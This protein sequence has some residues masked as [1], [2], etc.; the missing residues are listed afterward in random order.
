MYPT[1]YENIPKSKFMKSNLEGVACII[2]TTPEL[3]D[4][5]PREFADLY[6]PHVRKHAESSD[7]YI[8]IVAEDLPLGFSDNHKYNLPKL[9]HVYKINEFLRKNYDK[10]IIA[11]CDAGISRS[12]FVSF[13]LDMKNHNYDKIAVMADYDGAWMF[14]RSRRVVTEGNIYLA[15]SAY[16]GFLRE[17]HIL[18]IEEE[19]EYDNMIKR[20]E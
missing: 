13:M 19:V 16:C 8:F 14:N 15:N 11:V 4:V 1:Q 12:G 17:S 5:D 9:E 10:K 18:T 2:F 7:D 3:E 20:G 6:T